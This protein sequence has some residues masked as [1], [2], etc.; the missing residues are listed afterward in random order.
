MVF[1]PWF[2]TTVS[3]AILVVLAMFL[4]NNICW[5]RSHSQAATPPNEAYLLYVFQ[6][7]S[8]LIKRS[9]GLF[10]G[11]AL[12]FLGTSIAFYTVHSEIKGGVSGRGISVQL[13]THSPG[14]IAMIL[15]A[16][17]IGFTIYSK[18]VFPPYDSGSPS[19]GNPSATDLDAPIVQPGQPSA[20]SELDSPIRQPHQ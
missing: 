14:I 2:T 18:D 20:E 10:A 15:G 16:G 13:A 4:L 5:F 17:L 12:L 11:F 19:L 3:V 6:L 7:H 1:I 9:V 8:S